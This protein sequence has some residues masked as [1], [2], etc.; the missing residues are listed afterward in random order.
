MT[1]SELWELFPIFLEPHNEFWKT[2]YEK[3]PEGISLILRAV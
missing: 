1:L 2:Y 3:M